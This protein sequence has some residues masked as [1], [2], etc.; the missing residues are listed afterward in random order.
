[1]TVREEMLRGMFWEAVRKCSGIVIQLGIT[2]V[3]ARLLTP[4]DFGIVAIASVSLNL[5]SQFSSLGI[6]SAI[7]FRQDL[8]K[9]DLESMF[10]ISVY[11][12]VILAALFFCLARPIANFY[13]NESLVAICGILSV[14]LLF[15]TW[16]TVTG[17]LMLK[18]KRF[19]FIAWRTL[20]LQV[21]S[22]GATII[23]AFKGMGMYALLI[24]PVFT[25]CMVVLINYRQYPMRFHW[26]P[27]MAGFRK[28]RSFSIYQFLTNLMYYFFRNTDKLVIGKYFGVA[29]LGYYSKA[30]NLMLLP[31]QNIVYVVSPVL[32]P[33]LAPFQY[34]YRN[35]ADKSN[36]IVRIFVII[37]FPLSVFFYHTAGD[38]V[39]IVYGD[40]WAPTIPVFRILALS[41]PFQMS[42]SVT[43]SLFQAA[44]KTNWLFRRGMSD[45][46][47]TVLGFIFAAIYFHTLEAMAWAWTAVSVINSLIAYVFLYKFVLRQSLQSIVHMYIKTG[48][49]SVLL[50]M[51]L[52]VIISNGGIQSH[53]MLLIVSFAVTVAMMLLFLVLTG[54]TDLL[55]ILNRR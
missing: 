3:L 5:L 14:N 40:G 31:M 42:W 17:A 25:G 44:G 30:Y 35:L 37:G 46:L 13:G 51:V 45:A 24:P 1:M 49:W 2:A 6:G 39:S 16:N 38:I 10:S 43:A 48:M 36:K 8:S 54:Q 20:V 7:I 4:Q 11:T 21:I 12:G 23:V 29:E 26:R 28:I 27:G 19:R 9:E 33:V 55:R 41:L 15:V 34:D 53:L 32:L 22:G 18:N 52:Q 50:Y 47:F